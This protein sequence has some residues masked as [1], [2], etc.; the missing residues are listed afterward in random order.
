MPSYTYKGAIT[1][2]MI[3]IPM[4]L[5]AAVKSEDI[6]FNMLDKTTMSRVKYLKTCVDCGDRV[7]KQE[8][9][10]KGYEYEKDRYVIFTDEDFEKLKSK[11]DKNITIE[12]FVDLAE[13]DPIYYDKPYYVSPTGAEKAY[14]LLVTAMEAEGKA[15]VARTVMGYKEQLAVLRVA[16]GQLLLSTLHFA[17]EVRK[18]P[19]KDVADAPSAQELEMAKMLIGGMT[20][21][22]DVAAYK[23]EY[24]ERVKAA[25]EAKVAGEE[26]TAPKEQAPNKVVDLMQALEFSLR[27]LHPEDEPRERKP[28]S[29]RAAAAKKPAAAKA[30]PAGKTGGKAA[31]KTTGRSAQRH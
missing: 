28:R 17:D 19:A 18:N 29:S 20:G 23:D 2:G 12:R 1:F 10:V 9:I 31:G 27:Q 7:V 14:A 11:K 22:F 15:A 8:D 26:L 30:K 24:R 4:T 5:T 3:Y 6:G 21:A 16:G 25:I 13:I